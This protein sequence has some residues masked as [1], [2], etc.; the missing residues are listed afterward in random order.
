MADLERTPAGLQTIIPGCERRTLPKSTTTRPATARVLR[1]QR[2]AKN[3]PLVPA[4]LCSRDA[5]RPEGKVGSS[6][7]GWP[8]LLGD[9]AAY[10][11]SKMKVPTKGSVLSDGS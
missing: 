10:H 6:A 8:A 9:R 7:I 2:C 11:G 1:P 4:H 5:G 3:S